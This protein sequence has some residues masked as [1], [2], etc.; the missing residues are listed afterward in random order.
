[1]IKF[2]ATQWAY[3][4]A[5]FLYIKDEL[6]ENETMKEIPFSTA[7]TKIKYLK[8]NLAKRMK[9]LYN[10]SYQTLTKE[11]IKDTLF[12]ASGEKLSILLKY[13]TT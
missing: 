11:I 1:M 12:L 5:A 6:T 7:T 4:K 10:E 8:R 13:Y 3:K 9:K 2:Q